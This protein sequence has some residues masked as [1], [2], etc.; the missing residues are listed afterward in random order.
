MCNCVGDVDTQCAVLF[1]SVKIP[2][3]GLLGGCEGEEE[4]EAPVGNLA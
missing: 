3:K 4:E 1:L 2:E